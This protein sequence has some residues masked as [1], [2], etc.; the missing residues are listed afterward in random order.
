M[1]EGKEALEYEV[2]LIRE[3]PFVTSTQRR[4]SP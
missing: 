2:N 1:D 4:L 3:L